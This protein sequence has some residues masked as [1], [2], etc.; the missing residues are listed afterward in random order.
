MDTEPIPWTVETV[1][2]ACGGVSVVAGALNLTD[3]AVL[4]MKRIGIQDRHWPT[5]I[6][7]SGNQFEPNDLFRANQRARSAQAA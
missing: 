2:R 1:I 4:K 6:A 7:L 3:S 5:L